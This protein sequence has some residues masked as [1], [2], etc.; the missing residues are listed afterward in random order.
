MYLVFYYYSSNFQPTETSYSTSSETDWH[1]VE[2]EAWGPGDMA[3]GKAFHV[4]TVRRN[5]AA[6]GAVTGTATYASFLSSLIGKHSFSS[7][8]FQ[9]GHDKMHSYWV[10]TVKKKKLFSNYSLR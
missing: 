3:A 5:P 9:F 10:I 8:C 2:V 4:K 7:N 1:T 6:V